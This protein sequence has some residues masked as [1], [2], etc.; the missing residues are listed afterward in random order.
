MICMQDLLKSSQLPTMPELAISLLR[1]SEDPEIPNAKICETI[2]RD[3]AICASLLKVANSPLF[4]LSKK[5]TTLENAIPLL[6]M[7][8]VTS[9]ALSFSLISSTRK[10]T[11][12]RESLRDFWARAIL[13][14]AAGN[15]LEQKICRNNSGECFLAGL[16][17]DIGWLALFSAAPD[18][19]APL[20]T[21]AADGCHHIDAEAERL[22]FDHAFLGAW[23]AEAWGFPSSL[24]DAIQFHHL[25]L[26][27]V[28]N[29][30]H[31]LP[32]RRTVRIAWLAS[33]LADAFI[34]KNPLLTAAHLSDCVTELFDGAQVDIED[35]LSTTHRLALESQNLMRVDASPIPDPVDLLSQANARL[36]GLAIREHVALESVTARQQVVENENL[37]LQSA[38]KVLQSQ[39]LSDPLTGVLNRRAFDEYMERTVESCQSRA[40]S[41]GI[42]FIDLDRF[43]SINDQYGHHVG[44][45]VLK[46]VARTL[47]NA[48]RTTDLVARYGG[49]EFVIVAVGVDERNLNMIA[50]RVRSAVAVTPV[51][52]ADGAALNVRAS[53]G[54][55]YAPASSLRHTSISQIV[56]AADSAMYTSKGNGGNQVH[57]V[58]IPDLSLFKPAAE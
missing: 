16:L 35:V 19:A 30:T 28:R 50:E 33:R 38:N 17:I 1:L 8:V 7:K 57:A 12:I 41:V 46:V 39:S 13:Q 6:G 15:V 3:P 42:L 54:S 44:D 24:R 10:V 37:L 31:D 9:L 25:E 27:E 29:A 26:K 34:S 53:I 14:A 20:L 56:E 21:A 18:E 52:L 58:S 22:G 47:R 23:M 2:K 51:P 32:S 36:A 40:A 48:V 55:C 11:G 49:E 5:V 45:E 43:K 4:G